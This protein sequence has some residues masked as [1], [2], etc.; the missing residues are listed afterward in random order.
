MILN[1]FLKHLC[2]NIRISANSYYNMLLYV[3]CSIFHNFAKLKLKFETQRMDYNIFENFERTRLLA[4]DS[5]MKALADT[6]VLIFGVGGVGSWCAESLARTGIGSITMVDPDTVAQSNINRQLPAT[7]GTVG[8]PKVE[9]LADRL[10]SINP[11]ARIEGVA[12]RYTPENAAGFGIESYDYVIDA[13]DSLT[14]KADLILRC[15][16]PATAPRRAF[17]SSMG[18]ARK[19]DP[20][21]ISTAEFWK[22]EGC[23]LAR[24]LRTRFRRSGIFPRRKFRCV[25]SP[26]SLPHRAEGPAGVNGTFAHTTAI[27]GLTLASLVIRAIYADYPPEGIALTGKAQ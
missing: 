13:I 16:D 11:E 10:A 4:G 2:K 24:A 9:V 15:T 22:V 12:G 26:E 14:D 20:S 5:M 25:Y 23:P 19:L 1:H 8:L 27:F 18:A 17:F 6:R 7:T 3:I 21:M